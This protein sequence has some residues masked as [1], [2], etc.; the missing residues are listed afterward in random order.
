MIKIL[1][2]VLANLKKKIII[3]KKSRSKKNL[4]KKVKSYCKEIE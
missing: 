2:K 4:K 1:K 3:K